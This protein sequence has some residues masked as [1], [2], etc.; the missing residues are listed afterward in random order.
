L[1]SIAKLDQRA[2]VNSSLR[3][4]LGHFAATPMTRRVSA[5]GWR[6]H[7]Q[8][9]RYWSRTKSASSEPRR[10]QSLQSIFG[11]GCGPHWLGLERQETARE[12]QDDRT[13]IGQRG[14]RDQ[15]RLKAARSAITGSVWYTPATVMR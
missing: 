11:C 15:S 6:G 8:R 14:V 3:R 5:L 2:S 13:S 7:Q 1:R 12:K 9:K 10:R 4:C